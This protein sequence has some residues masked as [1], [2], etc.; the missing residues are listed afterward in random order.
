MKHNCDYIN[1]TVMEVQ[2]QERRCHPSVIGNSGPHAE[3]DNLC[4]VRTRG[5]IEL[6]VKLTPH[7][8]TEEQEA[9]QGNE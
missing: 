6:I 7:K 2:A 4:Q 3:S 5:I 9:E 8:M 1:N